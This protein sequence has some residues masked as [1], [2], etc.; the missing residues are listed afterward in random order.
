M[1]RQGPDRLLMTV[2]V[3][4]AVIGISVS[5][6][7]SRERDWLRYRET[8]NARSAGLAEALK[9]EFE[10]YQIA[11]NSVKS[12]IEGSEK[13]TDKEFAIFAGTLM[14]NKPEIL[15]IDYILGM[16]AGQRVL[17][18]LQ[19]GLSVSDM[20][21]SGALRRA[22]YRSEYM[23]LDLGYPDEVGTA[24]KGLD[25]KAYP[26][27]SRIL[28]KAAA[29]GSEEALCDV[30][31]IS[32]DG[33]NRKGCVIVVPVQHIE[34]RI[35]SGDAAPPVG[36]VL[37][38]L[39]NSMVL[40]RFS[41]RAEDAGM[42]VKIESIEGSEAHLIKPFDAEPLRRRCLLLPDYPQNEVTVEKLGLS[43]KISFAATG[44]FQRENLSYMYLVTFPVGL[45]LAAIG[46]LALLLTSRDKRKLQSMVDERVEELR[47]SEARYKE[48]FISS[49]DPILLLSSEG[50]VEMANPAA[51]VLTGK[52]T[53]EL[54]G[55]RLEELLSPDAKL[56]GGDLVQRIR[57]GAAFR[58][59]HRVVNASGGLTEVDGTYSSLPDG[60][61]QAIWRD[62]TE[63]RRRQ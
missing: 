53:G 39:D 24:F 6:G 62:I 55:M 11:I 51:A 54:E 44:R 48:M 47:S 17:W 19:N 41:D 38:A 30:A 26:T 5:Y 14:R 7:I 58:Y 56:L 36:Y 22:P 52:D 13:V 34:D 61:L 23:V 4:A 27:I 15:S 8:F 10:S 21:E 33:G 29:S 12:F 2:L 50:I 25:L 49:Y 9:E 63:Y 28:S 57:D 18:E 42:L 16:D 1:T 35:R 43:L 20:D 31:I 60:K 59:E 40:E 3:I 37:A 32:P 45:L 46:V